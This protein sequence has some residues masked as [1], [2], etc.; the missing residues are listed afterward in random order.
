MSSFDELYVDFNVEETDKY[1]RIKLT[2]HPKKSI[3]LKDLALKKT[4]NYLLHERI[5]CNGFQSWSES[6]EFDIKES[7]P[8]IK[9]FFSSKFRLQGDNQIKG[10]SRGKG[11]FHSWTYSYV[12][13]N[14]IIDFVGSLSENNAFTIIQHDTK[15]N[16]LSIRKE[17]NDLQLNH[18]FPILDFVIL[19]GKEQV[20]FD[21]YF[22]LMKLQKPKQKS[23]TGWN[24]WY[25]YFTKISEDIILKNASVFA[26]KKVP[27]DLIQIDDGY[28]K[29]VGDWLRI[30]PTFPNGMGNISKK[31]KEK[32]FKS[33]IWIAPFICEER[34]EVF[35][36]KKSWLVKNENGKPLRAGYNSLWKSWFYI[37]DFYNPDVQKYLASVFYTITKKWNFDLIKLDFLY[38][39]CIKPPSNKTRGQVMSDALTFV[40]NLAKD[41]LILG[42]GV[43]LGSAFGKVDFCR[44]GPDVH[45][46]W[47]D[48]KMN[49]LGHREHTSTIASLRTVLSRWQLNS[50][51]FQSDP[52]VFILRDSNNKLNLN[53]RT[54]LLTI[55]TL[56]GNLLLTSDDVGAYSEEQWCEFDSIFK[57]K[58]SEV[59]RVED[60]G[61][62]Q[63]VIHFH[64][65]EL[66]YLAFC[67]LTNKKTSFGLK[68]GE[69]VLEPFESIILENK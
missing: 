15:S 9:S 31:I 62:D 44:V 2:V 47:E 54:T 43:P 59:L 56:L 63:F 24:S 8:K 57:W 65:E 27:I 34:S 68:K 29:H 12:R 11:R 6:R 32:S 25:N 46:K 64:H 35:Q 40:R 52:D 14:E 17:C 5:F 3:V 10:I 41:Q 66:K 49:W 1:L 13:S 18:S 19:S 50:R 42:C 36:N 45:L 28:Q 51:A 55:N 38:A 20:V 26:E 23:L 16:S 7:I 33:G 53:Q 22:S 58:N 60:L 39:A 37:L 21:R 4:R 48:K 30:K 67:N 69:F 61:N